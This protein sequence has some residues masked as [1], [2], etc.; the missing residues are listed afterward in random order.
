MIM[1][2][3]LLFKAVNSSRRSRYGPSRRAI[4]PREGS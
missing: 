3:P 4:I 2:S 1:N